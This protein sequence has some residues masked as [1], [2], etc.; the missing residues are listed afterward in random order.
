[1]TTAVATEAFV[2]AT[3]VRAQRPTS[4]RP[5]DR[6][7]V[8]R[9]GA[10]EGFVGGVCTEENVRA[11]ALEALRSGEPL[12]LRIL[13]EVFDTIEEDGAVTVGNPCLSGGGIELFLEPT[14]AAEPV[15]AVE[16]EHHCCHHG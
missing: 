14:A 8:R 1:V 10:L 16:H 5:G 4:V 15:A 6:A 12:L 7:I 13:P 9:D 3:V 11:Y 2:T